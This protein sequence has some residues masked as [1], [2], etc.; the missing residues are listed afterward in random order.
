MGCE[1][2]GLPASKF[3]PGCPGPSSAPPAL[4]LGM[5]A[6]QTE[7]ASQS[8]VLTV[9]VLHLFSVICG[10]SSSVIC[11]QVLH[12]ATLAQAGPC[13]AELACK[14]APALL[15]RSTLDTRWHMLIKQPSQ[16]LN[17]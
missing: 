6:K 9:C 13:E 8:C 17:P 5:Q 15:C 10:L 2:L 7:Q 4:E 11:Y 1:P 14:A 3:T 16:I 12:P